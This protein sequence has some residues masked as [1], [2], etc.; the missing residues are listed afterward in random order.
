MCLTCNYLGSIGHR[1]NNKG[2]LRKFLCP[3]H[4]DGDP[5]LVVWEDNSHWYCFSCHRGGSDVVGLIRYYEFGELPEREAFRK[6]FQRARELGHITSPISHS[7]TQLPIMAPRSRLR[8]IALELA[9]K[10]YQEQLWRYSQAQ[11]YLASRGV[12]MEMAEQLRFGFCPGNIQSAKQLTDMTD[13]DITAELI[14]IGLLTHNLSERMYG[15][16]IIPNVRNGKV[17]WL[18]G[19]KAD[20]SKRDR[21][22]GI[23]GP[24]EGMYGWTSLDRS[25]P[26]MIVEGVFDLIPFLQAGYGGIAL[27]GNADSSLSVLPVKLSGK[28]VFILR[29]KGDGG[30]LMANSVIEALK[31]LSNLK[32][33]E[34]PE[35]CNDPSDWVQKYG[36]DVVLATIS[37]AER[38]VV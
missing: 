2:N 30:K 38:L 35:G 33:I 16:I 19:R 36:I 32:V 29:D 9:T 14:A 17:V 6:A 13:K 5:S 8:H 25:G 15:R 4:R 22:L 10:H 12:T 26:A 21:Y 1:S 31:G 34:P 11:R 20:E 27:M 28:E 23:R 18:Q 3:L 24:K 7:I 37:K